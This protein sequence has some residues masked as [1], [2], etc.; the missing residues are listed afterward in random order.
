[1]LTFTVDNW[2]TAQTVTVKAGQDADGANDTGTLTHTASGGDYVTVTKDLPV[3][4]TDD[5]TAAIVLSGMDL[6]VTEGDAAGS[7]YTVKLATQPSGSVTVTIS[8]HDGTDLSLSGTTLSSNML[9]FTV[10]NWNT[11]QTV[12]VKAGQDADGANDTGTLTHTASG[13]DYVT[14]TKDLPVTVTDDDTAAIV[15][16]ETDLTVTEGDA[17]GSSYTV[18]L[19]T[20]PSTASRSPS[21]DTTART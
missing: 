1:M 6:T 15:L 2:N 8:G 16:S 21:Q 19:A 10:D 14:V 9:T 20:Q 17:A 7:S 11:A 18:K 4:I 13:G 3:T 12:T 5:D